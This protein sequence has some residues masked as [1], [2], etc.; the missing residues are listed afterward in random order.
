MRLSPH[1]S[2]S[3]QQAPVG[4][5]VRTTGGHDCGNGFVEC[6]RR[7]VLPAPW[8]PAADPKHGTDFAIFHPL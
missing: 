8:F 7:F 1:K 4:I 6:Y 5:K 2:D 3:G